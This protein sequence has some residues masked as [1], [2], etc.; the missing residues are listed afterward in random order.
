MYF[1]CSSFLLCSYCL[2]ANNASE[3]MQHLIQV[4]TILNM[5][6]KNQVTKFRINSDWNLLL[7]Q[8]NE[9]QWNEV[10]TNTKELTAALS[11]GESN[12]SANY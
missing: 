1:F 3:E 11:S 9:I 12:T 8:E 5:K 6:T 4:S 10:K 2:V 7:N